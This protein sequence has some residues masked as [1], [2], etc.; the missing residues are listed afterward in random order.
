MTRMPRTVKVVAKSANVGLRLVA[1]Y[2]LKWPDWAILEK[3]VWGFRSVGLVEPSNIFKQSMSELLEQDADERNTSLANDASRHELGSEIWAATEKERE[4]G[5]ISDDQT[6]TFFDKRYGRGKWRAIRRRCIW[7]ES[8]GQ[9]RVIDN[10]RK[11]KRN[12]AALLVESIFNVSFDVAIRLAKWLRKLYGKSLAGMLQLLLGTDDME[13]T[14]RP[15]PNAARQIQMYVVA[16]RHPEWKGNASSMVFFDLRRPLR[17]RGSGEQFQPYPCSL[18]CLCP[19][20][21]CGNVLA[22]LR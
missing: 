3:Y 13:N 4:L 18:R 19:S 21:L 1:P 8:Q 14:Y 17:R 2:L 6:K 20:R 7:Q 22:L 12:R 15:M 10:M 11:S 5:I 9:C 16:I